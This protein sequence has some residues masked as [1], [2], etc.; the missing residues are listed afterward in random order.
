MTVMSFLPL[1]RI[2]RTLCCDAELEKWSCGGGKKNVPIEKPIVIVC[3]SISEQQGLLHEK[4]YWYERVY[5]HIFLLSSPTIFTLSCAVVGI[6]STKPC[7]ELTR[8]LSYVYNGIYYMYHSRLWWLAVQ[9]GFRLQTCFCYA[10]DQVCCIYTKASIWHSLYGVWSVPIFV[11]LTNYLY[12]IIAFQYR[13][14]FYFITKT[15]LKRK[16]KHK[17]AEF[18]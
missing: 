11:E 12:E 7:S 18:I 6:V 5:T 16:K 8:L 4:P 15:K 2:T 1:Q 14:S 10:L 17:L 3:K 9:Q 13:K